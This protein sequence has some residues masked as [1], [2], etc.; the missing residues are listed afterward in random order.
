[1]AQAKLSGFKFVAMFDGESKAEIKAAQDVL[2]TKLNDK[3]PVVV[4]DGR[5]KAKITL[6]VALEQK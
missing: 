1:M 6:T 2:L 5:G 4:S 3:F